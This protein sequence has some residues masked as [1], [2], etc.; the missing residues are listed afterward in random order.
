MPQSDIAPKLT[1]TTAI[2]TFGEAYFSISQHVADT[3]TYCLYLS[4]LLDVL[5]AE[6]PNYRRSLVLMMD[7]ASAHK[8]AITRA[9]L[10]RA[11]VDVVLMAPYGFTT[12]KCQHNRDIFA[13]P[14]ERWF[15]AFK[16][17]NLNP[18][19]VK[20]TKKFMR[21]VLEA[22]A[23]KALQISRADNLMFWHKVLLGMYRCILHRVL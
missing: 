8:S 16:S 7:G 15:A 19:K 6:D 10:A 4:R 22:T 1:L 5:H 21:N 12:C 2:D 9:F 23:T 20:M 14:C 11:E 13:A 3:D 17:S 18:R